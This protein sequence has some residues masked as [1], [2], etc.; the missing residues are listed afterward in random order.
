MT[1]IFNNLQSICTGIIMTY[2][3]LGSQIIN[4]LSNQIFINIILGRPLDL[5]ID[6]TNTKLAKNTIKTQGPMIWNSIN[7]RIKN[8]NSLVS[9]KKSFKKF[10]LDQY[11]SNVTTNKYAT[12]T[13]FFFFHLCSVLHPYFI[14]QL[15]TIFS[16]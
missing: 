6:P 10:I 4:S 8:C 2:F 12:L 9:F 15:I 13:F 5:H 16:F 3:H 14:I 11:E 1:L 7:K